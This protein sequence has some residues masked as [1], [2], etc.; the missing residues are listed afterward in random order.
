MLLSSE[1]TVEMASLFNFGFVR[2]RAADQ[3]SLAF[4]AQRTTKSVGGNRTLSVGGNRTLPAMTI[5][6]PITWQE[7]LDDFGEAEIATLASAL[8]DNLVRVAP[9]REGELDEP[10]RAD[11]ME[12]LVGFGWTICSPSKVLPGAHGQVA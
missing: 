2:K 7:N 9:K 1:E 3:V 10:G 11:E 6:N 4:P 12:G 8:K 5:F